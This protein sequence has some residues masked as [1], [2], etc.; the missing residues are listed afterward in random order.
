[1][2]K[3]FKILLIVLV[4]LALVGGAVEFISDD[5]Q[6]VFIINKEALLSSIQN[7]AMTTYEYFKSLIAEV[8]KIQGV[9]LSSPSK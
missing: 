4:I 3:V 9:D 7:G 1:M 6:W 2:F 5:R 8:D